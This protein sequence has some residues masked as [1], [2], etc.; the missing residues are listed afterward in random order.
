MSVPILSDILSWLLSWRRDKVLDARDATRSLAT[1]LDELAQLMAD[2][3]QVTDA[4]G[5]IRPEGTQELE[6]RRRTVWNRWCTILG[7]QGYISRD[8]ETQAEIE[9]A[10]QIAHAA[11]G[12]YITEI[13]LV[14]IALGN[15]S[16][17]TEIRQRFAESIERLRN[18]AVKLRLNS[19][20]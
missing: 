2:V 15:G 7:T 19:T 16:V 13:Y 1:E 10:I 9:R 6:L 8:S 3:L 18:L 17:P 5:L 12:A 4:N 11:P 20:A 14:Q